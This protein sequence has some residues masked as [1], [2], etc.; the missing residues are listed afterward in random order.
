MISLEIEILNPEARKLLDNL[1][2]LNLI[3]ITQ[4]INLKQEFSQ[5]LSRL[6]ENSD[7]PLSLDEIQQEV[8][9]VRNQRYANK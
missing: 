4:S 3:R 7:T 9:M 5:L 2:N 1:A 8:E 6:R